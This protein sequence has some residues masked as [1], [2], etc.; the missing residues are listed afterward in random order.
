M[1]NVFCI[2]KLLC[3]LVRLFCLQLMISTTTD[4]I[5]FSISNKLH[6]APVMA[7]GYFI[8]KLKSWDDF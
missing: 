2:L 5:W 3:K 6:V 1:I 7:L 8:I 4:P